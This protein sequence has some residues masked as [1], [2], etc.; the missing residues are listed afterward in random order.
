MCDADSIY[1]FTTGYLPNKRYKKKIIIV[2]TLVLFTIELKVN[3][4]KRLLSRPQLNE[5]HSKAINVG[6]LPIRV[7]VDDFRSLNI[8]INWLISC[9]KKWSNS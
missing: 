1:K 8:N 7:S 4:R 3:A 6:F 2:M 9:K 5:G